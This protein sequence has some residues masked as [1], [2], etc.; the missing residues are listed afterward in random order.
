MIFRLNSKMSNSLLPVFIFALLSVLLIF[1]ISCQQ[2]TQVPLP[3]A[4][5]PT[6]TPTLT[7]TQ[8]PTPN[9]TPTPTPEPSPAPTPPK[10]TEP[11]P[12]EPPPGAPPPKPAEVWSADGVISEREYLSEMTYANDNYE[13]RWVN[14]EQFIYIA[15]KVKTNGWVSVAV[16]PGSAMK[17]ADMILAFV[18]DGE[19]SI[20]DQFSTGTYGPHRPDTTL[21]GTDDIIE[22]GGK[23]ENGYTIIEFKRALTTGDEYDHPLSPG[24]NKIIWSYGSSDDIGQKHTSRGYG[25]I[26]IS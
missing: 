6:P 17:D 24:G 5:T 2:P 19:V 11:I 23:E 4:P 3:P 25:E 14:D 12:P 10:P 1:S 7:P 15:I 20:S 13:I 8:E 16:Q 22:F 18:T 26:K 9:P 21:G